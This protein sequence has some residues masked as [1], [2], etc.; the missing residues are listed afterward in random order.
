MASVLTVTRLLTHY[1]DVAPAAFFRSLHSVLIKIIIL[2]V[3]PR[4]T[5][6]R[7]QSSA[8][9]RGRGP[10]PRA[11]SERRSV[12]REPAAATRSTSHARSTRASTYHPIHHPTNTP[13]LVTSQP[14][15]GARVNEPHGRRAYRARHLRLRLQL[16]VRGRAVSA[17]GMS[18]PSCTAQSRQQSWGITRDRTEFSERAGRCRTCDARSSLCHHGRWQQLAH[19]CLLKAS[20]TSGD[21]SECTPA[22]SSVVAKR[23]LAQRFV[24]VEYTR[25]PSS[26]SACPR[27]RVVVV[28]ES[29]ASL[30]GVK[31]YGEEGRSKF[32]ILVLSYSSENS[33]KFII[34]TPGISFEFEWEEVDEEAKES[35]ISSADRTTHLLSIILV[36][37][38]PKKWEGC[39]NAPSEVAEPR[40]PNEHVVRLRS[41]ASSTTSSTAPRTSSNST[42]HWFFGAGSSPKRATL[43][44]HVASPPSTLPLAPSFAHPA[45]SCTPNHATHLCRDP[46]SPILH[47]HRAEHVWSR[48]PCICGHN[49]RV[50]WPFAPQYYTFVN[51]QP[52][53]LHCFYTKNSTSTHGTEG[54]DGDDGRPCFGQQ[55]V[56]QE[57]HQT[58]LQIGFQDCKVF[59]HSVDAQA[60]AAG[61]I[62]IQVIGEM[63]NRNEAWR[64]FVQTFFLAEQPNGYF[65]LNNIF[66]FLKEE[67]VE[68]DE[69]ANAGAAGSGTRR[70]PA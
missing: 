69:N 47:K 34:D 46:E 13:P 30:G 24:V 3:K 41:P 65:V 48:Q 52:S 16:D 22:L 50:S 29:T 18:Q 51:K 17:S 32:A 36:Y 21:V 33:K 28:V 42:F 1:P 7:R 27:I 58:I 45:F 23:V 57:I 67:S 38:V 68:D 40:V 26:R 20:R 12:R 10:R 55:C 56:D 70:A 60:S 59:I 9:A 19:A 6:A 66:R 8:R 5:R 15:R 61:G 53:R 49:G 63:S 54:G 39:L 14:R 35:R 37:L 4:G 43:T 2:V 31:Q 64:K 44:T 62:I 11:A 25:V